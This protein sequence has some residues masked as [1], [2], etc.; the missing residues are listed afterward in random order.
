MAAMA[1]SINE[2]YRQSSENESGKRNVKASK[3]AEN[4][5]RNISQRENESVCQ[6]AGRK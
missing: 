2:Q 3:Q 6:P 5:R 1:K 4:N